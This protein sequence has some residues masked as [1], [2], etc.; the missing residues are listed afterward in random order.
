MQTTII[1]LSCVRGDTLLR[2]FPL[3]EAGQPMSAQGIVALDSRF[4]GRLFQV[5]LSPNAPETLAS[6][7]DDIGAITFQVDPPALLL[8]VPAA[9]MQDV[10]ERA[11]YDIQLTEPRPG[12]PRGALVWTIIAGV[13]APRPDVA[14]AP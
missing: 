4:T 14:R 1:D 13:I 10:S 3:L 2:A 9:D 12:N 8:E 5:R 7:G 6:A 11:Y